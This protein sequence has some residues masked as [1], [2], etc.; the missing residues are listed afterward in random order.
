MASWTVGVGTASG[1]QWVR[2]KALGTNHQD[3]SLEA[4]PLA[5]YLPR[6]HVMRLP[7]DIKAVRNLSFIVS[8]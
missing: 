7:S 2:P 3:R 6:G 5:S 1:V 4:P 8:K